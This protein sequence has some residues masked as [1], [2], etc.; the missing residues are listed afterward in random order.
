M[1]RRSWTV[2]QIVDIYLHWQAGRSIQAIARSLGIDRKTVRKYIRVALAAGFEP[3]VARTPEQ[4]RAFVR[5]RFPGLEDPRRRSDRFALLDPYRDFIREGLATNRMSTVHRRLVAQTGLPVSIATFR[6]YVHATFP[7]L[8][9]PAASVPVWRPEVEPGEEAQ[10]DFGYLGLW[11][12]PVRQRTMRVYA[13]TMV[14]SYSRHLFARL[15]TRLDQETWQDGHVRAFAFFGGIPRRIVPDNLKPGVLKPDLYDP[16][17]NRTYAELAAHYGF[18]IDPARAGRPKDKPRVERAIPYLRESFW[19][20]QA[21]VHLDAANR[22]LERWCLE[23]AGQR[24]HGTTRRR[25]VEVFCAEERPR[26]LPLP[27]TPW[28]PWIWTVAK[29]APDSYCG[30]AGALYS[31]PYTLRGQRLDVRLTPKRVQ[32]YRG[33]D[34]VKT[35]VRGPKGSRTTDP[36]DLPPDR[37]AFYQ[38]TPPWCLQ[39]ARALGPSVF[40]LVHQLLQG[41][42]LT[43]LRQAQGILRLGERFGPGRLEAACQR[44][45]EFGDPRYRTVKNILERGYDQASGPQPTPACRGDAYL[46]GPGAYTLTPRR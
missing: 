43:H 9:L 24:V 11:L 7:E 42:T 39:Q 17:L 44:A 33:E 32:F 1:A 23:V 14:L 26:L 2:V 10:V 36:A 13:F 18:L 19:Q 25:P 8:L 40:E 3:G 21:F 31:V 35:H 4:W 38:R 20:G 29:V 12:D 22:E 6:R 15:V 28:E 27:A 34:L 41:H 46:R 16:V 37:V 5:E 30:V 45:L